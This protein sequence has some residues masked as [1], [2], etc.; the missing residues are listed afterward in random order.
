MTAPRRKPSAREIAALVVA[1]VDRDG[2]FA[3]AALEAELARAVQ[4][5]NRNRALATELVYGSLRV[6][7]WLEAEITRFV[8]RGLAAVDERVRAHLVV[9]AYQLFFTRVPAFAA[10]S[11]AVEAVTI[12]RG[13]KVGAFANAVLR[14]VATRA[15]E[16]VASSGNRL[17]EEATLASVPA[18]LREALCRA[19][20]RE[21]ATDFLRCGTEPPAVALRVER[22]GERESWILT[23][24]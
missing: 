6:A 19:L 7:P 3:A 8:P 5:G 1:R 17:R 18:W 4:L 24:A 15:A 12:A 9:A 14:R 11:E 23:L 20:S 16:N 10:V 13:R 21:G 22:G 2:A